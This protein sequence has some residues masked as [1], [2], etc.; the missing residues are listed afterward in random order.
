MSNNIKTQTKTQQI[1]EN[2]KGKPIWK[3]IGMHASSTCDGIPVKVFTLLH[4]LT[5]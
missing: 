5:K 3:P 4:S 2:L 1:F